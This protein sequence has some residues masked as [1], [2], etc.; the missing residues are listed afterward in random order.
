LLRDF[1]LELDDAV[2]ERFGPRRTARDVDVDQN[3]PSTPITMR[4]NIWMK[5]R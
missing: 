4:P 5:R 3:A 2:Q 1:A